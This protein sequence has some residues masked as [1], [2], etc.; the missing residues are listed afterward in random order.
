MK[1]LV[2]LDQVEA[3]KALA[4][5]RRLAV[6]RLL[7]LRPH[8]ISQLAEALGTYPAQIRHHVKALES[9]GLISLVEKKTTRNYTELYYGA[10]A[11]AVSLSM[12]VRPA[13][14][15]GGEPS[16]FGLVSDDFAVELLTGD[17]DERVNF[18]VAATGSLD[19]LL[20]LRQG[21]GDIAGCH[22]LDADTNSYNTPYIR[23]ILPDR[24]VY[25][26]TLADREQGLI[27][28]PGNPLHLTA[29]EDLV[30]S[31]VRIVNRNRGSGTRLWL[32]RV[33]GNLGVAGLDIIGF[34]R[35]VSTHRAAARAVA[36]GEADAA[37]GIAAAAEEYHLEF[38]PLHMERYELVIPA[39]IYESEPI[40]RLIDRIHSKGYRKS[41]ERIRGY[42]LHGLGDER[43]VS[44]ASSPFPER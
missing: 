22:L 43:L 3:L 13:K 2:H 23:H 41:V 34:D 17:S 30:G 33:L 12:F 5:T 16:V 26:V 14:S 6:M 4:D 36:Q 20:G 44:V 40:A 1:K 19:G 39:D 38:V 35:E 24:D 9:V 11:A 27:V 25:V 37:F 15:S 29:I 28:Q 18:S 32:D 10:A 21:W 7:L 42:D 8:T 31:G